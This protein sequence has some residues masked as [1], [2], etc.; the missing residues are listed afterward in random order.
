VRLGAPVPADLEAVVLRCLAK[1]PADRFADAAALG[2]ALRGCIEGPRWGQAEASA[3]W[4]E[5]G[6]RLRARRDERRTERAGSKPMPF[7]AGTQVAVDAHGRA[8]RSPTALM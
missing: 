6:A 1:N 8:G 4:A 3:W 5:H 7:E 2:T